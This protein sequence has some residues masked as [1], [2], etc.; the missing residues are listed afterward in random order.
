APEDELVREARELGLDRTDIV[1]RRHLVED[2]RARLRGVSADDPVAA[3]DIAVEPGP[4]R[5]PARTALTHLFF[6]RDRRGPGAEAEA[7]VLAARLQSGSLDFAGARAAGDP[8]LHGLELAPLSRHELESRFGDEFARAA[9]ELPLG[10]WAGPLRSSYGFHVVR[11]EDRRE[12]PDDVVGARAR[13]AHAIRRERGIAGE[14]A[15][16]LAW[17]SR[18]RIVVEGEAR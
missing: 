15:Q 14:Q 18:H 8:F 10:R 17:R 12:M 5:P 7:R 4:D 2:L 11:I 16:L 6:D 13:R 3:N 9:A 1:I